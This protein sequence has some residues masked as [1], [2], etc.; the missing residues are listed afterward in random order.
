M[1]LA[2]QPLTE[3][4]FDSVDEVIKTVVVEQHEE[5]IDTIPVVDI[6]TK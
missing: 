3:K 6:D 4:D 2:P 5:H 1:V